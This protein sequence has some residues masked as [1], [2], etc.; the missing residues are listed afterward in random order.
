MPPEAVALGVEADSLEVGAELLR[1][2]GWTDYGGLL[3][4]IGLVDDLGLP[5][6]ISDAELFQ[7]RPWRWVLHRLAL[8]LLPLKEDDPA[9]L[10]FAGLGPEGPPPSADEDE[11]TGSELVVLAEWRN[12]LI[13]ALGERL[14]W[15]E[16]AAPV[17]LERVCRRRA[18]IVAD[19]GWLEVHLSVEDVST[20]I[21]RAGLDLD[22][23]FLSWLGVVVRF[24]YA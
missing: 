24:V 10:A 5:K 14:E 1:Q 2:V 22:P 12:R 6:E 15:Q 4:L 23:G 13:R 20:E 18:R 21:R 8:E 3:Y 16:L 7:S 19:P 11:P 9:T 17:L